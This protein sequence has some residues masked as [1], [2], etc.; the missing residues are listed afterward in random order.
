MRGFSFAE[1]F[2]WS[3]VCR[4]GGGPKAPPPPLPLPPAAIPPTLANPAVSAAG[5]QQR[6]MAAAAAANGTLTN[7]GGPQGL[8]PAAGQTAKQQLG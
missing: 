1:D 5:T 4:F 8:V 7:E 6:Q 3:V 2:G